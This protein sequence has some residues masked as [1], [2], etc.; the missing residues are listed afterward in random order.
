MVC[1]FILRQ[2]RRHSF[3]VYAMSAA[4][5]F[6]KTECRIFRGPPALFLVGISS[7]EILIQIVP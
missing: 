6:Y 5:E 3:I 1:H 2:F 4:F 7:L